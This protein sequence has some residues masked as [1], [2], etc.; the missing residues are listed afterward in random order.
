MAICP[1]TRRVSPTAGAPNNSAFSLRR[2]GENSS[3]HL[4]LSTETDWCEYRFPPPILEG[5]S[6]KPHYIYYRQPHALHDNSFSQ[7]RATSPPAED[8][9]PLNPLSYASTHADLRPPYVP[10]F[11]P[12]LLR[13]ITFDLRGWLRLIATGLPCSRRC[14]L[15]IPWRRPEVADDGIQALLPFPVNDAGCV[16]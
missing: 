16:H 11:A 6:V 1:W 5:R 4:F 10:P 13:D 2:R 14:S 8:A 9:L 3:W 7:H 15:R 12:S